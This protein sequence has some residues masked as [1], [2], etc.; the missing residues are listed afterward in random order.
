MEVGWLKMEKLKS[1]FIEGKNLM[2]Y[3]NLEDF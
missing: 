1:W 3:K 2:L